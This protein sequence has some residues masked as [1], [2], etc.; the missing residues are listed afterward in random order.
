MLDLEDEIVVVAGPRAFDARERLLRQGA[1]DAG[2]QPPESLRAQIAGGESGPDGAHQL[3]DTPQ[4]GAESGHFAGRRGLHE[5]FRRGQEGRCRPRGARPESSHDGGLRR[6][7]V[8]IGEPAPVA[9]EEPVEQQWPAVLPP[10]LPNREIDRAEEPYEIDHRRTDGR[11]VEVV[12]PAGRAGQGV[13]FDVRVAVETGR[14]QPRHLVGKRLADPPGPGPAD[15]PE[16]VERVAV[17]PGEQVGG[18]ARQARRIDRQRG[19]GRRPG[20]GTTRRLAV[21]GRRV[22]AAGGERAAQ[23]RQHETGAAAHR[24]SVAA[25]AGRRTQ[26]RGIE[27]GHG[28]VVLRELLHQHLGIASALL[29]A[30]PA[31]GRQV[32]G[33]ALDEAAL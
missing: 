4:R 6:Q 15:E 22:A 14:R 20:H 16:V 7:V 28:E 2:P 5:Q 10:A 29:V 12:E 18:G 1:A 30:L 9:V 32:V 8:W 24:S 21:G 17:E 33:R 11:I 27:R 23:Q 3:L 13:L 31:L 19:R 26:A 25:Q